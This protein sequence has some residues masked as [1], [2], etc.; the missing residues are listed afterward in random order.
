MKLVVEIWPPLRDPSRKEANGSPVSPLNV[1]AFAPAAPLSLWFDGIAV[2][3]LLK[4]ISPCG[5]GTWKK[6]RR[7]GRYSPPNF[8]EWLPLM[9]ETFWMKSQTLLY[10]LVGSQSLAPTWL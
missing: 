5:Y 1:P 2:S 7:I 3:L 8:R 10:S 4:F 6:G 9:M